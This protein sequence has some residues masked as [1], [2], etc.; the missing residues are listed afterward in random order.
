[1][2]N[3]AK[4]YS[5]MALNKKNTYASNCGAGKEGNAGFQ[6]GNTCG[7]EGK[8]GGS[9]E[10]KKP[11]K[12]SKPEGIP[13]KKP[14]TPK[15]ARHNEARGLLENPSREGHQDNPLNFNTI[16]EARK[17]LKSWSGGEYTDEKL[18]W[19]QYGQHGKVPTKQAI[20]ELTAKG[21]SD[22]DIATMLMLD[23]AEEP[24][25]KIRR[26]LIDHNTGVKYTPDTGAGE[27]GAPERSSEIIKDHANFAAALYGED[28][29]H[30][31]KVRMRNALQKSAESG[32]SEEDMIGSV[33]EETRDMWSGG[34]ANDERHKNIVTSMVKELTDPEF[35]SYMDLSET[36]K[37]AAWELLQPDTGAVQGEL[38]GMEG[39]NV[40]IA[41]SREAE[42]REE[43]GGRGY[44][45][46]NTQEGTD[47]M[48]PEDGNTYLYDASIDRDTFISKTLGEPIEDIYEMDS[49]DSNMLMNSDEGRGM[50]E[51]SITQ[52]AGTPYV[53][54]TGDNTYNTETDLSGVFQYDVFVP[55]GE[56]KDEW[57]YKDDVYVAIERH[58]GGDVRGNYGGVEVFKASELA[59]SGF[60]DMSS[61]W[62]VE[63]AAGENIDED[64]RFDVGYSS[65][66][67]AELE[68]TLP[69]EGEWFE[70]RYYATNEDG[71]KIVATPHSRTDWL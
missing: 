9:E 23:P 29:S 26:G 14:N 40:D 30:E 17:H 66:P 67:T 60:F 22:R 52:H 41:E 54:V 51:E 13:R 12:P 68:G 33:Y 31:E 55:E 39:T 11:S 59:E 44:F 19:L 65:N 43:S 35:S 10:P 64:G 6:S 58:L 45:E 1:M 3:Y 71:V 24:V 2:K 21:K 42:S 48:L 61:G 8:G 34:K 49:F 16:E 56:E 47:I 18:D 15:N 50:L 32:S 20:D 53:H 37:P 69:E 4:S 27:G 36:Q 5:R 46:P 25:D 28:F 63:N 70:G 57:Y 7:G 62:S 38:E